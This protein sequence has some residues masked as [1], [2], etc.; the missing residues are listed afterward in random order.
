MLE[1]AELELENALD[2]L[3]DAERAEAGLSD[4]EEGHN[5]DEDEESDDS[6]YDI[7]QDL[8]LDEAEDEESCDDAALGLPSSKRQRTSNHHHLPTDTTTIRAPPPP[9]LNFSRVRESEMN[10][11]DLGQLYPLYVEAKDRLSTEVELIAGQMLYLPAGNLLTPLIAYIVYYIYAFPFMLQFI[12][13][14]II[15]THHIIYTYIYY[16]NYIISLLYY[17]YYLFYVADLLLRKD[18]YF[19]SFLLFY[20]QFLVYNAH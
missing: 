16:Y 8:T 10:P 3:L 14:R 6:D 1:D 18:I 12:I 11:T 19:Y 5:Y 9:P 2:E 13:T 7:T 15:Y 4:G 17:Y 20:V